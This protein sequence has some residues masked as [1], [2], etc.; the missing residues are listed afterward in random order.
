MSALLASVAVA[1]VSSCERGPH[2]EIIFPPDGA[3]FTEGDPVFLQGEGG[4]ISYPTDP[5]IPRQA[6]VWNSDRD[7]LLGRA[8]RLEITTLSIG[9][10]VITLGVE[11][12][13]GFF[14]DDITI[15][16]LPSP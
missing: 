13:R 14:E 16:I 3:R 9:Q 5:P 1:G 6:R 11:A 10:H 7:G 12:G 8:P 4:G 15:H 2:V